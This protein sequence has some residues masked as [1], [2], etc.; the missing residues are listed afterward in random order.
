MQSIGI[1]ELHSFEENGKVVL[2][3]DGEEASK[4][5]KANK[6]IQWVKQKWEDLK[7]LFNTVLKSIKNLIETGK[8]KISKMLKDFSKKEYEK[9]INR[10]KTT[11]SKGNK[12]TFGTMSSWSGYY[13]IFGNGMVKRAADLYDNFAKKAADGNFNYKEESDQLKKDV[14]NALGIKGDDLTVQEIKKTINE[15]MRGEN[16]EVDKAYLDKN[17]WVIFNYATSYDESAKE[18]SKTL[19]QIKKSFGVA[20]K[21]VKDAARKDKTDE[22]LASAA[23][24]VR[25]QAIFFSAVSGS[26]TNNVRTRVMQSMGIVI[27]LTLAAK[28]KEA[29]EEE[30]KEEVKATGESAIV[31]SSFQTE[32]ASLFEF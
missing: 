17:K 20:E 9:A 18:L 21:A 19:S 7:E 11:D 14:K 12:K 30:K 31:P 15:T 5:K 8:A 23:K 16:I 4:E 2:E 27:K 3:A 13:E 32:L 25:D 29:K 10:L 22:N 1:E 24:I 28:Q 6:I 26:I